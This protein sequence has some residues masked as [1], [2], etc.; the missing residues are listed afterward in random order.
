MSQAYFVLRM[1]DDGEVSFDGPLSSDELVE[2]ITPDKD[3]ETCYGR[4][5]EFADHVPGFLGL[6]DGKILILKGAVVVPQPVQTVTEYR[7]P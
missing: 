6:L 3:G 5:L 1:S 2:R 7:L 4:R